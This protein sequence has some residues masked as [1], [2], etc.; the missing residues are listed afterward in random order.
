MDP[1]TRVKQTWDELEFTVR[2]VRY[3]VFVRTEHLP[4]KTYNG[5]LWLPPKLTNFFGE[6]PHLQVI[7]GVVCSVGPQAAENL[8]LK[9]GERVVFKRLE[10]AWYKRMQDGTYFGW[11]NGNHIYGYVEDDE[12][13]DMRQMAT[14]RI[15][16]A[17]PNPEYAM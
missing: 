9:S 17:G 4:Q 16:L 15:P 7:K 8:G 5:T 6:L 14:D 2:P 11:I 10:F 12:D 3:W 13:D 1:T